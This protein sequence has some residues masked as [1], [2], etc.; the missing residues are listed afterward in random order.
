M[1]APLVLVIVGVVLWRLWAPAMAWVPAFAGLLERPVTKAG[2]LPF[3]MGLETAGGDF[4]GR[5]VLL[6]LHHKR[7]RNS[8]GYLVVAVQPR[9]TP[10]SGSHAL[11]GL[12]LPEAREALDELEGRCDL[13]VSFDDGWL[14]ARWQPNGFMI[15][16]GRFDPDRWRGVLQAMS[17]VAG[18]LEAGV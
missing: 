6:A 1:L 7:G 18:S 4:Q 14:T 17:V 9:T 16:P 15:F 10:S 5:S 8:L 11:S 2:V 12:T 3:I 13:H